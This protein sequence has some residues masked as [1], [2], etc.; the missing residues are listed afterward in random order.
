MVVPGMPIAAVVIS[1]GFLILV[2]LFEFLHIGLAF[3]F[4]IL[5]ASFADHFAL[6]ATIQIPLYCRNRSTTELYTVCKDRKEEGIQE[7]KGYWIKQ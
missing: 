6:P 3:H 2:S 4:V 5:Q 1:T 7:G